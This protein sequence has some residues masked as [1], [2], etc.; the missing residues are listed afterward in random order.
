MRVF[1]YRDHLIADY[2][3]YVRSF[4]AIRDRRMIS[5]VRSRNITHAAPFWQATTI[6]WHPRPA[7]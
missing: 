7:R 3:A 5:W 6:C 1:E 2:A 4:I